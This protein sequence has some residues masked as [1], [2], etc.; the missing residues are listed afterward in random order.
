[1]E[2]ENDSQDLL[3]RHT[4]ELK[5]Q[6]SISEKLV[7]VRNEEKEKLNN[8]TEVVNVLSKTLEG[9]KLMLYFFIIS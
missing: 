2:K 5:R 3:D 4:K 6:L 7:Q 9:M 8:Q 1:M